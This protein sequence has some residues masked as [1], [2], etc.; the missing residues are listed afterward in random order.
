MKCIY[1]GE[2]ISADSNYCVYC[3]KPVIGKV[4]AHVPDMISDLP[5]NI[6][7]LFMA[8]QL[9]A[10]L[11]AYSETYHLSREDAAGFVEMMYYQSLILRGDK[12]QAVQSFCSKKN[13]SWE[14][15]NDIMDEIETN[16]QEIK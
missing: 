3:G 2:E 12:L 15:G 9:D 16:L 4:H 1:C 6:R 11:N 7:Y 10:A 5:A 8:D 13:A 14:E